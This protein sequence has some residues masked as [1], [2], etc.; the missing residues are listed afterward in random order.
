MKRILY[1]LV[2]LFLF[3]SIASAQQNAYPVHVKDFKKNYSEN[4]QV[5]RYNNGAQ[6]L[7]SY[8]D[9][10]WFDSFDSA[11]VWN[12]D[13]QP[14]G[15]W[16]IA[17]NVGTWYFPANAAINSTT[18]GN[19]AVMVPDDPN[20]ASSTLHR[21]STVNPID[22]STYSNQNLVLSYE[23]FGARFYDTLKVEVSNNGVNWTTLDNN[24]DFPLLSTAGGG[25]L[26]NPTSRD[27][28]VPV[29][30]VNGSDLYIRFTWDADRSG[31]EG[32]GYGYF[33]DDIALFNVPSNDL[34]IDKTAF[35]ENVGFS[36]E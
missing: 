8:D 23:K 24:T 10:I 5:F 16:Q 19:Y 33:I 26:A 12:I 36:Y 4:D 32:I 22:I 3:A 28:F 21:I 30:I 29:S 35:F 27:L 7:S 15:G 34:S 13:N 17:S 11:S 1:S 9:T 31:V 14:S 18:G 25:V 6:R 20:N 2:G